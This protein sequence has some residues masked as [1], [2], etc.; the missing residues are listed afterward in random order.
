MAL[1]WCGGREAVAPLLVAL[2]DRDWVTRQAAHVALTN[3]T[4]MEKPFDAVTQMEL[5]C[6]E[7]SS[8]MLRPSRYQFVVASTAH[9]SSR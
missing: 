7:R 2:D 3:L 9:G 6:A 8:S 1:A 5:I 4:G